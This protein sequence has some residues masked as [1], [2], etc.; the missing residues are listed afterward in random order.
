MDTT[1]DKDGSSYKSH[2]LSTIIEA[3]HDTSA[4]ILYL[5]LN[6]VLDKSNLIQ[7]ITT[8]DP[9]SLDSM[10]SKEE[11]LEMQCMLFLFLVSNIILV[12]TSTLSAEM[13]WVHIFKA[14]GSMK[15]TLSMG[16]QEYLEAVF[17]QNRQSQE[18]LKSQ[19]CPGK[20]VPILAFVF[21]IYD[22]IRSKEKGFKIDTASVENQTKTFLK[23][24]HR[25][26]LSKNLFSL[27]QNQASFIVSLSHSQNTSLYQLV[28]GIQDE[29]RPYGMKAIRM[30]IQNRSKANHQ[31]PKKPNDTPMNNNSRNKKDRYVVKSENTLSSKA[32]FTVTEKVK[33]YLLEEKLDELL[34]SIP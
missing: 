31:S 4:N 28:M 8:S 16:L 12:S 1:L 21:N 32:W 20:T 22:Y 2:L 18:L 17:S 3:Y 7:F 9:E 6:S 26:S 34:A 24:I 10:L 29:E 25:S 23:Y 11:C 30:W 14:L 5:N 15:R 19:L 33:Y 27:D 13:E